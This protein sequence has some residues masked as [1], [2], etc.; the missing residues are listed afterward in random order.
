MQSALYFLLALRSLKKNYRIALPLFG[1][2]AILV[3][4]FYSTMALHPFLNAS[5]WDR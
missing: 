5:L 3:S 1:G 4:L 2:S